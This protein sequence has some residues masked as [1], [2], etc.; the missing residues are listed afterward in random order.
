M[1]DPTRTMIATIIGLERSALRSFLRSDR[2]GAP[3]EMAFSSVAILSTAVLC[4]DL[5]SRIGA[6]N[7]SGRAAVAMADYV[8]REAAPNGDEMA[9]LGRFLH[10]NEIR[11]PSAV[12][13]VVSAFHQP[14]G[15][16]PGNPPPALELLWSDDAVRIGANAETASLA[17]AC[18][19]FTRAG[20][21]VLPA[22]FSAGMTAG[23]MLVIVEVCARLTRQ[24]SLTGRFV[25]GD[26]YRLY[27]LPLRDTQNGPPAAPTHAAWLPSDPESV[28]ALVDPLVDPDRGFGAA[29]GAIRRVGLSG[30]VT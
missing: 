9:A 10:A 5:Y 1:R 21:P 11:V 26:I 15:N 7:A 13:Y 12:V 27:A 22:G 3:L 4:F 23:E 2:G 24:G 8:S 19:R 6:D 29:A 30:A 25:A 14:P 18:G 20:N 17:S 28:A 16:P